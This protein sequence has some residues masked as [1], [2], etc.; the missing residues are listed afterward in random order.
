MSSWKWEAAVASHEEFAKSILRDAGYPDTYEELLAVAHSFESR[1][2]QDAARIVFDAYRIRDHVHKGQLNKALDRLYQLC[3]TV[4]DLNIHM[5]PGYESRMI[6]TLTLQKRI[7]HG[8]HLKPK[9]KSSMFTIEEAERALDDAFKT[10]GVTPSGKTRTLGT[11]RKDAAGALT[12]V[13]GKKI[14]ARAIAEKTKYD[15]RK[16]S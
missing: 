12:K 13:K 15:P 8:L 4:D 9:G 16:G 1:K 11:L 7:S 10:G 14:T 5:V 2:Y 6:D 3:C